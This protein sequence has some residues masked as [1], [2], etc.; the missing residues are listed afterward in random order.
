MV[1]HKTK[2]EHKWGGGVEG[3][4]EEK[5]PLIKKSSSAGIKPAWYWHKNRQA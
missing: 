2:Q 1:Y 3:G 4:R 5:A